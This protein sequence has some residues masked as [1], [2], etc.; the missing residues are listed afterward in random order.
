[1][2]APRIS[3][4]FGRTRTTVSTDVYNVLNSNAVLVQN[5]TFGPAWQRPSVILGARFIKFNV[6]FDF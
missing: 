2:V 5:N 4:P 6:Q 3:G 1:M